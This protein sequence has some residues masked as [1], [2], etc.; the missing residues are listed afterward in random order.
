LCG[1]QGVEI[2]N[3]LVMRGALSGAVV[4]R[5]RNYHVP[6]SNTAGATMILE[7]REEAV[8]AL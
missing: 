2:L 1:S 7:R 6:I 4:E 5:H 3:W 8:L